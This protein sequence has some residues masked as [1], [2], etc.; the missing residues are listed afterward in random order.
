MSDDGWKIG[1]LDN[2]KPIGQHLSVELC[3]R[4]QVQPLNI[5]FN[6]FVLAVMW[7]VFFKQ[8]Q[9]ANDRA[10]G[11]AVD[12]GVLGADA[13]PD[14]FASLKLRGEDKNQANGACQSFQFAG[15]HEGHHDGLIRF[16]RGSFKRSSAR[17][18]AF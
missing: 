1:H 8:M 15:V 11:G 13:D 5:V 18:A 2:I 12:G 3:S 9:F 17:W 4:G 6:V 10:A 16:A 14:C 7:Q